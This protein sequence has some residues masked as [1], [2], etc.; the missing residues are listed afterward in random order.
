MSCSKRW[1]TLCRR[2][3][4]LLEVEDRNALVQAEIT[5]A[6]AHLADYS[7]E[8]DG[9]LALRGR[10]PSAW[11]EAQKPEVKREPEVAP[12]IVDVS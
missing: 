1:R 10:L 3:V 12:A 11:A 2:V 5:H 6:A 7:F 8:L 9:H 4:D